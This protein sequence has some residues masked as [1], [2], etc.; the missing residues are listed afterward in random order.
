MRVLP[1]AAS[2]V[3][4]LVVGAVGL[5]TLPVWGPVWLWMKADG[6]LGRR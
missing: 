2:L 6:R 5:L 1:V 3:A 4:L